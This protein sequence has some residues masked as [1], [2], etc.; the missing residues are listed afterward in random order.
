MNSDEEDIEDI[1]CVIYAKMPCCFIRTKQKLEYFF[2]LV[3]NTKDPIIRNVS[4]ATV[5]L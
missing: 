2:T 3:I 5:R 1:T 4:D